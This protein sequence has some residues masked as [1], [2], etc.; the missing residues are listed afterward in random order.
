MQWVKQRNDKNIYYPV[1]GT[2]LGMEELVV[3][4][5]G[6]KPR[7][8]QDG[9]DDKNAVHTVEL[10]ESFWKSKFFGQ[11]DIPKKTL[12]DTFGH[13]RSY[14][15]HGEGITPEHFKSFKQL[16]ESLKILGT[17]KNASGKEFVSIVESIKYP[18]Y[19]TQFHPEKTQFE[20]RI[21]YKNLDRSH[22]TI[23]TMSSFAF[24]LVD[25]VRQ[26]SKSITE[27][28]DFIQS[29]FPYYHQAIN[30]PVKSFE[31][32]YVFKNYFKLT[33]DAEPPKPKRV[34]MMR[35]LSSY[36]NTLNM[37]KNSDENK[38]N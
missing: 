7:S 5:S 10:N 23:S 24:K 34:R 38:K 4:F 17:S 18:I 25:N 29:F 1:W 20:K 30:S 13:P 15:F 22:S 31:R 12:K 16:N 11:L 2:C 14:Y 37:I 8:L 21:I 6:N 9:F 33:P 35:M 19:M 26:Y 27:T 28:P 32:I 3:S 36:K